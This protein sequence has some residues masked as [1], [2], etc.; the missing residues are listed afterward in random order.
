MGRHV[1]KRELAEFLG[2]SENTLTT[3]QREGMPIAQ[4]GGRGRR[5]FYD[6]EAVVD[7]LLARRPGAD[8]ESLD[9]VQAR[10]RKDNELADK[11]AME[12]QVRRGELVEVD[13]VATLWVRLS[14]ECKTRLLS[15]PSKLAP[16]VIGRTREE[17]RSLLEK[18]I[19]ECLA[20]FA[21]AGD[22]D[23]GGDAPASTSDR[24]PVG[25]RTSK[26]KPG[27]ERGA[28]QVVN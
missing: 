2:K 18:A 10:A 1:S 27:G 12:N 21:D 7:W 28:R 11:T 5:N 20:A 13:A 4:D 15:L 16:T 22:D 6:T 23:T 19:H 8:G 9:P 24:K 25:R 14:T 3:W 17:A 26:A